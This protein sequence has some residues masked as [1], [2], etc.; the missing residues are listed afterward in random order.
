MET[1]KGDKYT[2]NEELK[3]KFENVI[4]IGIWIKT[5]G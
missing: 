2:E 3:F 5:I 4:A 1:E